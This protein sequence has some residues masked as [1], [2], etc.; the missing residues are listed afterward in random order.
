MGGTDK[1][2]NLVEV[3]VTQHAMWH[4]ANW[5]LWRN[6]EDYL[7][8][9]GLAGFTGKEE[10]IAE[11]MELGRAKGRESNKQTTKRLI[12]EGTFVL[13]QPDVQ[14]KAVEASQRT[15][16]DLIA[17]GL[18]SLQNPEMRAR[19]AKEDRVKRLREFALGVA[20]LQKPEVKEKARLA[21]SKAKSS[22]NSTLVTCP[23]CGKTG[24]QTNMRR[25]HFDNCK[26]ANV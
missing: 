16:K 2:E 19:R 8:W 21:S 24:G 1:V 26:N 4:Y 22:Q 23:H 18:H 20:A 17:Q 3:S 9:K 12:S 13:L 25:Y 11:V 5:R 15:Q 10:I 6:T 7:A 14:K